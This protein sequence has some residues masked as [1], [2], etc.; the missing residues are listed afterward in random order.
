MCRPSAAGGSLTA[1]GVLGSV[2]RLLY[3]K[4]AVLKTGLTRLAQSATLVLLVAL[5]G[6][7]TAPPVQEMSDARQ[8][9]AVAREAGAAEHAADQLEAAESSLERAEERLSARRYLDARR[10]ALQAKS[11]A[12]AARKTAEEARDGDNP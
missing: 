4:N 12:L 7:E 1:G 5:A 10:E 2:H 11:K 8:A 6:C 3:K 9:I